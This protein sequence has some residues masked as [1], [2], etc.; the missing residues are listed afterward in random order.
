LATNLSSPNE[1]SIPGCRAAGNAGQADKDGAHVEAAVE[2]VLELSEVSV[3]VLGELDGMVGAGDRG[4]QVSLSGADGVEPRTG[5][6][7]VAG[8]DDDAVVDSR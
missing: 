7:G 5:C 6:T 4:L 2:P 8:A 3:G 1:P